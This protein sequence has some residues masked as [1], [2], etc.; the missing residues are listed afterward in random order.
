MDGRRDRSPRLGPGDERGAKFVVVAGC[1]CVGGLFLVIQY[2]HTSLAHLSVG[3]GLLLVAAFLCGAAAW[4]SERFSLRLF[5][6]AFGAWAY[7]QAAL[8]AWAM[9][10]TSGGV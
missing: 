5:A 1:S 3:V 2:D 10:R 6:V 8:L 7:A 4:V 9:N